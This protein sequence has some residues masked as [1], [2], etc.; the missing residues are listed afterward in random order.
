MISSTY[1][2]TNGLINLKSFIKKDVQSNKTDLYKMTPEEKKK[3]NQ[4]EDIFISKAT[5]TN[6]IDGDETVDGLVNDLDDNDPY[7]GLSEKDAEKLKKMR[8][9]YEYGINRQKADKW[10]L[11]IQER[12]D[13]RNAIVDKIRLKCEK[14]A[15]LVASGKKVSSKDEKYLATNNSVEYAKA[16]MMRSISDSFGNK[17][18]KN[19]K[20]SKVVDK[21][22]INFSDVPDIEFPPNPDYTFTQAELD[23]MPTAKDLPNYERDY[24]SKSSTSTPNVSY[25]Q[26]GNVIATIDSPKLDISL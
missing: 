20:P 8:D 15:R 19:E 22:D 2:N 23:G 16:L 9:D 25:N 6:E 1:R 21:D 5:K 4:M 11:I 14:I 3:L 17:D 12:T 26:G 10:R 24:G 13:E 7:A 18:D